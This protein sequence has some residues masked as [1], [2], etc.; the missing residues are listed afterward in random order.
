MDPPWSSGF[1]WSLMAPTAREAIVGLIPAGRGPQ[2]P[3]TGLR[4]RKPLTLGGHNSE[5]LLPTLLPAV[6]LAKRGANAEPFVSR[7]WQ[8]KT[9]M[10]VLKGYGGG[11]GKE[12]VTSEDG[13]R[14]PVHGAG[15][16]PCPL[17]TKVTPT[18]ATGCMCL[19]KV[20]C[21]WTPIVKLMTGRGREEVS[22]KEPRMGQSPSP[23]LARWRS[24]TTSPTQTTLATAF[25]AAE[26]EHPRFSSE[27]DTIHTGSVTLQPNGKTHR[28]ESWA[29]KREALTQQVSPNQGR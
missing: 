11:S 21:S 3:S 9:E 26:E 16:Q 6:S 2:W 24:E 15:V 23:K 10:L 17:I 12:E 19:E 7:V 8:K 22:P 5:R 29:E 1:S 20:L 25:L 27:V 14:T 4:G 28:A 18:S 13:C